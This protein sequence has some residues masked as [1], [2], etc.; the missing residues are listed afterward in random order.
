M[1]DRCF[2]GPGRRY[3]RL[4]A[5]FQ[6][7]YLTP[8]KAACIDRQR[9]RVS[10]WS[11]RLTAS[12]RTRSREAAATLFFLHVPPGV[13]VHWEN[14][15]DPPVTF[16]CLVVSGQ[17]SWWGLAVWILGTPL[18]FFWRRTKQGSTMAAAPWLLPILSFSWRVLSQLACRLKGVHIP[19]P[20][21]FLF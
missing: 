1:T 11:V 10:C 8:S 18:A 17:V 2:G 9:G 19:V 3:C 13:I 5:V 16:V 20:V 7:V 12:H 21:S 4:A 6:T 14:P 15:R